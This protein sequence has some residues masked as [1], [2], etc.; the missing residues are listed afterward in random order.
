MYEIHLENEDYKVD[1]Y[2][3]Y[4]EITRANKNHMITIV[5]NRVVKN[6]ELLRSIDEGYGLYKHETRYP[7]VVLNIKVDRRPPNPC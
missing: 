4:P 1:G 2:I 3:S 5:D 7:I 6:S